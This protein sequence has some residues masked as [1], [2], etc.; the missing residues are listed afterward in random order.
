[1]IVDGKSKVGSIKAAMER[2]LK[3]LENYPM[4]GGGTRS[5][6]W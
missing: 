2:H 3:A 1:L 6:W 5:S 4:L